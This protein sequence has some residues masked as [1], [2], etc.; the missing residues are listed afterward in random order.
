VHHLDLY[1]L[2]PGGAELESLGYR[3]LRAQPGLVIVEW[4]E[5]GGAALGRPDLELTLEHRPAG[6]GL[7]GHA[8]TE[9]GRRWLSAL[10]RVAVGS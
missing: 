1:R 2:Q 8:A 4:P 7:K 5:R 6:R 10:S 9:A 3:D